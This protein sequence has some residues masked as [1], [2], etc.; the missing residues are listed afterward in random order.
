MIAASDLIS[1]DQINWQVAGQVKGLFQTEQ[2]AEGSGV[3]TPGL[4]VFVEDDWTGGISSQSLHPV[5][6]P[7]T[8]STANGMKTTDVSPQPQDRDSTAYAE[9]EADSPPLAPTE[10][11]RVRD[12][13]LGWVAAASRVIP[14]P[15]GVFLAILFFLPWLQIDGC[16]YNYEASGWHLTTGHM[17]VTHA[18][19]LYS[20]GDGSKTKTIT[21]GRSWDIVNDAFDARPHFVLAFFCPLVM[22]AAGGA[23]FAGRIRPPGSHKAILATACLGAVTVLSTLCLD[24]VPD[25]HRFGRTAMRYEMEA[26]GETEDAIL[27]ELAK[28]D[29]SVEYPKNKAWIDKHR[30]FRYPVWIS[31]S[32]YIL[33]IL[34]STTSLLAPKWL[35][36]PT[37]YPECPG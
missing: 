12:R 23:I 3:R 16:S 30:Q 28:L 10:K 20:F 13:I 27:L 32:L 29:K 18:P 14:I 7:R 5:T 31:L 9:T 19:L 22:I 25:M 36:M 4:S 37:T 17:S 11:P 8:E 15:N 1:T 21:S 6:V 34:L 2:P 24:L 33:A 26:K 35:V